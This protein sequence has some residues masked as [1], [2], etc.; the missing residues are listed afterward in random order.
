MIETLVN[1]LLVSV[2]SIQVFLQARIDYK[3]WHTWLTPFTILSVPF[4]IICSGASVLA[5]RLGYIRFRPE[6]VILWQVCLFFFWVGAFLSPFLL[7]KLPLREYSQRTKT[8]EIGGMIL[9]L[10]ATL[11]MGYDI[12]IN[13]HEYGSL[14]VI[15]LLN[16]SQL[17]LGSGLA[18][19]GQSLGMFMLVVYIGTVRKAE[20]WKIILVMALLGEIFL[21]SVKGLLILPLVAGLL[22]RT[23]LF[24]WR[25]TLSKIIA[26]SALIFVMSV[27]N[28]LV[29]T[30]ASETMFFTPKSTSAEL[31]G[32]IADYLFSGPL[33]LGGNLAT[34][35][36]HMNEDDRRLV[37]APAI[38]LWNRLTGTYYES[39]R[40]EGVLY[41]AIRKGV[42]SNVNTLFGTMYLYRGILETVLMAFF[43]GLG[44]TVMFHLAALFRNIWFEAGASF[45]LAGLSVGWFEYYYWHSAFIVVLLLSILLMFA[46]PKKRY[47]T[48]RKFRSSMVCQ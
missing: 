1:L 25:L 9:G 13:L 30:S 8:S 26:A 24:R 27:T 10:L 16:K 33:T 31:A 41:V 5:S 36:A 39:L 48:S 47:P 42:A 14:P 34:P 7:R 6:V 35:E 38:N 18:S 40:P 43:L 29:R 21:I 20:I 45:I 28:Y 46:F 23:L 19:Y 15:M 12:Y 44:T 11:V 2:L 3:R 4:I 22:L 17:I 37:Y 32:H